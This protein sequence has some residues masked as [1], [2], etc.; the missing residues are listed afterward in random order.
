MTTVSGNPIVPLCLAIAHFLASKRSAEV[1]E[2]A[3]THAPRNGTTCIGSADMTMFCAQGAFPFVTRELRS[4]HEGT[5][6][7]RLTNLKRLT[8]LSGMEALTKLEEVEMHTCRAIEK[9]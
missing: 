3:R 5:S 8:S 9:W 7:L 6:L 1:A 4:R 2:L